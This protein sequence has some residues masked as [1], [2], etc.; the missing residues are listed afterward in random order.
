MSAF[1]TGDKEIDRKLADLKQS[2]QNKVAR[3]SLTKGARLSAK[4]MKA[5]VPANLKDAK[6]AIGFKVKVKGSDQIIAKAGAAVGVKKSRL[7]KQ[8][9]KQKG[10]RAGHPGVGISAANIQ[11]FI[12]GTADRMTGSVQR[13]NKLRGNYRKS[14]GNPVHSTG[15]MPP[16]MSP[17]KQGFRSSENAAMGAI[18]DTAKEKLKEVVK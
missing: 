12:M 1:V 17:V 9:A 14:T 13:R 4:A 3:P 2:A 6:K 16:Q 15:R 7:E 18:R 8:L 11:W 5:A 10:K